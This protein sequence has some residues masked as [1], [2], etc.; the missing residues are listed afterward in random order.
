MQVCSKSYQNSLRPPQDRRIL[1]RSYACDNIGGTA[2]RMRLG[3]R[4][5]LLE[6]VVHLEIVCSLL[7]TIFLFLL[8]ARL[9]AGK[10]K[11]YSNFFFQLMVKIFDNPKIENLAIVTITSNSSTNPQPLINFLCNVFMKF[12][13]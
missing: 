1:F 9:I 2:I 6:Y 11:D 7:A 12:W 10:P 5:Y 8:A 3:M 13:I 4:R